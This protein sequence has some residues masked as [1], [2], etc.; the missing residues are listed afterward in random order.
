MKKLTIIMSA[1]LLLALPAASIYINR[2]VLSPKVK[3]LI[4]NALEE[5]TGKKVILGSVRFNMLR[6]IV[7]KDLIVY[8][9][10]RAIINVKTSSCAFLIHP[11]WNK[12]VVI[13]S[14]S[15]DS[16]EL[17]VERRPDG[18]V[19]IME[20]FLRQNLAP[21]R[22]KL[23]VRRI[24]VRNADLVLR[25]NLLDKPFGKEIKGLSLN[26]YLALPAKVKFDCDFSIP[27]DP[28]QKISL[29]GEYL[30]PQ[31]ELR[32]D[33]AITDFEPKEAGAYF[34]KFSFSLPAGKIDAAISLFS[35]QGAC[36]VRADGRTEGLLFVKDGLTARLD[37]DFETSVEY[38]AGD[39][40]AAC[41]GSVN[42][43]DME[44]DGAWG[45]HRIEN[46]RGDFLFDNTG[47]SCDN[48]SARTMGLAVEGRLFLVDFANPLLNIETSTELGLAELGSILKEN[49]RLKLP[50]EMDGRGKLFLTLQ[51]DP[52]RLGTC[53]AAG[54]LDTGGSKIVFAG[55][56]L[57]LEDVT[58]RFEFTSNQLSW[59]GLTFRYKDAK[60]ET[61]GTVTNFEVPGVRMSLVS[62]D[63]DL[64]AM[65][66]AG[67]NRLIFT[68]LEG[69]Y[70]NSK[71]AAEGGLDT[72][73]DNA[74]RA[75]FSGTAEIALDD[76]KKIFKE[77]KNMLDKPGL[78][79]VM[80]ARF[81][82]KG[83]T[84]GTQPCSVSAQLSSDS[85]SVY[86]LKPTAV[87]FNYRQESGIADISSLRAGLY[88]G[89]LAG[90]ARIDLTAKEM[91]YS[92]GVE[93]AGLKLG[94]LK[95]DT[96]FKDRDIAGLVRMKARLKGF[97]GDPARLAGSGRIDITDGKL[98]QLNLFRGLGVLLFTSDFSN[99][100][101]TEGGFDFDIRDK[102]I[103]TDDFE[104]KSSL[105]GLY[106]RVRLDF[107]N[108]I[109]A[110]LK[111]EFTDEAIDARAVRGVTTA[112][113]RYGLIDI[114]GTLKDPK[115]KIKADVPSIVED[116]AEA[117][118]R[119]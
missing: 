64:D 113:G 111:A 99:V 116:L 68:K 117:M 100:I 104:L 11:L 94:Q 77:S 45:I 47:L 74:G 33:I 50:A 22:Y 34:E 48:L 87:S 114:K 119:Q 92:A 93:I 62:D 82:V 43:R 89:T 31:K 28:V 66:S 88:G 35:G 16:P 8:D 40:S 51:Y 18:S 79:G 4:V 57:A 19:N 49:F 73:G 72:A 58:G 69:R 21:G 90:T 59:A 106:G 103:S 25:D 95:N 20:L 42:V 91:P 63:L 32:S 53:Q 75:D 1:I 65:F 29:A 38:R 84:G 2:V 118:F 115:Y 30:I 44:M 71:F 110:L 85:I 70:L 101:F 15:F 76:L 5:A 107:Q 41:S 27:G 109:D 61:C 36:A 96:G 97:L 112:I 24:A 23:I 60:Y 108:S 3:V 10:N 78:S 39:G 102:A 17:Y 105:L 55:A 98:W 26:A 37:S 67:E 7:L 9:G 46:I 13:P 86:G 80:R 12:E 56:R 6:G 14:I 83:D 54:Y 81:D 52:F